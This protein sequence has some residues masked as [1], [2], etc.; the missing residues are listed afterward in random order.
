[1][2]CGYLLHSALVPGYIDSLP[3]DPLDG[4]STANGQSCVDSDEKQHYYRYASNGSIYIINATM[5]VED[6]ADESLCSSISNCIGNDINC[7]AVGPYCYCLQ[8][9]M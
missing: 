7:G 5:E 4:K 8:N 1:M 3:Q 2:Q 6:S 9:P